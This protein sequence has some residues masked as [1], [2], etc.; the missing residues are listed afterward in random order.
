MS[1][2][3]NVSLTELNQVLQ[4]MQQSL[5][6]RSHYALFNWLQGDIQHFMPHDIVIVAWGNFSLGLVCYDVVSPLP[7]LRTASFGDKSIQPYITS[8]LQRWHAC[9]HAPL[10][11]HSNE[12]MQFQDIDNPDILNTLSRM[13]TA[14]V[15]GIKDQRGRQDCLY[16]FMGSAALAGEAPREALRYLLP[17]IDAA[18]RQVAHLPEQ[19][20]APPVSANKPNPS[21]RR[22]YRP[23]RTRSGHH[24]V[25]AQRQNQ[26]RDRHDPGHQRL[27]GQKPRAAHFQKTGRRQPRAGRGQNRNHAQRLCLIAHQIT[28]PPYAQWAERPMP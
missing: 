11:V 9:D 6:I 10:T 21:N 5:T 23:E 4:V 26:S 8:L 12:G 1:F 24:G 15:H 18:F 3:T 13:R 25:G 22:R 16:V 20:L 14:L 19:Y 28:P 17:Y 2:L 7:G 27:H